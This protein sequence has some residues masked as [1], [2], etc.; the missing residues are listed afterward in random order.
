[1]N[2]RGN[3]AAACE[4]SCTGSAK[5]RSGCGVS[6]SSTQTRIASVSPVRT[7]S[8]GGTRHPS[9]RDCV[10]PEPRC[11]LCANHVIVGFAISRHGRIEI[12]QPAD[13]FRCPF[14]N[15]RNDYP[16]ITVT[17]QDDAIEVTIVQKP[18]DVGHMRLQPDLRIE[19]MRALAKGGQS[20]A[21]HQMA[22]CP[23]RGRNI[24][25]TPATEPR[26]RDKQKC[27]HPRLQ[28]CSRRDCAPPGET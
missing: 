18:D 6:R 20:R 14:G 16:A 26:T 27:R 9:P 12:N 13:S 4:R 25:P 1:M 5:L 24:P 21:D 8:A 17:D 22:S 23:K 11:H 10:R 3:A 7:Y 2:A 28:V 19:Q 15:R